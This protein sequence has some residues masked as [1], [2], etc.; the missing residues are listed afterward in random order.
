MSKRPKN[1]QGKGTGDSQPFRHGMR[2]IEGATYFA[3]FALFAHFLQGLPLLGPFPCN[4]IVI[5]TGA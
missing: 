4:R 2:I 3:S 5:P 1:A